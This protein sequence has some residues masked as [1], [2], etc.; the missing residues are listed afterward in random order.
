[1]ALRSAQNFTSPDILRTNLVSLVLTLK[2]LG[3]D[4]V[5]SFDLLEPPSVAA[6]SNALEELYAIGAIDDDC[7]LTPTMGVYMAEMPVEP[8]IGKMLMASLDYG[9]CE[10]V[11]S[12]AA[13]LQVNE[14]FHY[15][16]SAQQKQ[17]RDLVMG[18][19]VDPSGDHV[20]FAKIFM[21]GDWRK[22][23]VSET[24]ECREEKYGSVLARP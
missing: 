5:Q 10:E 20:T 13:V 17:D 24:S 12:I 3:I 6:M 4:N 9:C 22:E 1:L 11:L 18:E 23:E 14:I 8:K 16:K 15:A 21:E 19:V 2:A 7:R